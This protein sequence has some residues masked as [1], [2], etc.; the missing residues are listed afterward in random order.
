MIRSTNS[1]N[2]DVFQSLH[3]TRSKDRKHSGEFRVPKMYSKMVEVAHDEELVTSH[4]HIDLLKYS[5]TSPVLDKPDIPLQLSSS[6][7]VL[8]SPQEEEARQNKASPNKRAS[9]ANKIAMQDMHQSMPMSKH[10]TP[11]RP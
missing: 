3:I 4:N 5:N 8:R 2:K 6:S 11:K 7:E 1:L 10:S 9:I